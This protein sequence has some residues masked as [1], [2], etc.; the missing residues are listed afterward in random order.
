MGYPSME[1]AIIFTKG[2]GNGIEFVGSLL[3]LK[4]SIR[5][6]KDKDPEKVWVLR[7]TNPRDEFIADYDAGDFLLGA[8]EYVEALAEIAGVR[9]IVAPLLSLGA[10][11]ALTNRPAIQRE[12]HKFV[13]GDVVSL[14]NKEAFN[15][16][17][18]DITHACKIVS[19]KQYRSVI[20]SSSLTVG[21]R[22]SSS[23]MSQS[24]PS[25]PVS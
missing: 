8:I 10:M 12:F 19:S 23:S 9:H 13:I 20:S 16:P 17:E 18:Y 11:G 5:T 4:N 24:T 21:H 25:S 2:K 1:G 15:G 6:S 3:L 7:A 22:S 14:V